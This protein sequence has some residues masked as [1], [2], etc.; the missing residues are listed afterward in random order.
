MT[1]QPLAPR[2][3]SLST[4]AEIRGETEAQTRAWADRHRF[5]VLALRTVDGTRYPAFQFDRYGNVHPEF[6]SFFDLA[7]TVRAL[8]RQIWESITGPMDD[9]GQPVR[10]REQTESSGVEALLR[11]AYQQDLRRL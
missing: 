2:L 8:P 9:L 1:K 4:L 10:P 5:E 11:E 3:F 6:A 7:Q